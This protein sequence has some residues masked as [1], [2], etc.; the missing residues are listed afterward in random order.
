MIAVKYYCDET[1][2]SMDIAIEDKPEDGVELGVKFDPE[3]SDD[4]KDPCGIM[5][6]LMDALT[7]K[8]NK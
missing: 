1:K 6:R 3:V 4:T 7:L 8:E 2:Q 5:G